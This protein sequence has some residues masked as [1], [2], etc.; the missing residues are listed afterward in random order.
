LRET[1]FNSRVVAIVVG[2]YIAL[3]VAASFYFKISLT[4]DRVVVLLVIAA[5]ATG[6]VRQFLKDWSIF[7]VVILAWQALQTMSHNIGNIK[8]HVTEMIDLDKLLFWGQVPTIWLQQRLYHPGHIAWY[9]V[10]ATTFY[11][12]HFVLPL[13]VAFLLWYA[14]RSVFKE[15]M[16][17]FLILAL[18]G[19]ATYVLYPAAPPWLAAHWHYLPPV[20]R[21]F[22]VVIGPS[23]SI[24]SFYVF[25]WNHL[26]WD[27]VAAVP[28]EHAAL[29][30]LCFLYARKVWKRAGWV[31]LPYCACV[32][33]AIVYLGEHYV[34]DVIVGVAY[35]ALAYVGVQVALGRAPARR[36][37]DDPPDQSQTVHLL[38]PKSRETTVQADELPE[39]SAAST[40]LPAS[41]SRL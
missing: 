10:A 9:D 32:W 20:H 14:N 2:A 5:L 1:L 26:G 21:I 30:F 34:T 35:A 41:P 27:A 4:P 33:L 6:R 11:G 37:R 16:G 13:G 25:I 24:S 8:P 12:M 40:R 28:S 15:F 17:S 3:V 36:N 19:F 31:L 7:A 22:N 39:I 29:P 38:T 18:A 23:Q